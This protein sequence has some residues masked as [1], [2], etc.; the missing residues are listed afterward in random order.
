MRNGLL[1]PALCDNRRIMVHPELDAYQSTRRRTLELVAD[2]SQEQ[3]DYQPRRDKWSLGEVMD[4]LVRADR[5]FHEEIA[6][7]V[8]L[9]RAGKPTWLFR[10]FGHYGVRIPFVPRAFQPLV[11]MPFNFAGM[12]LPT[13][14][15][16]K[17]TRP[18]WVP[19]RAP[20][21]IRPRQGRPV[22]ELRAELAGMLRFV[23]NTYAGNPGIRFEELRY[24]N[25]LLG[26]THVPGMLAFSAGHEERHQEQIR[27]LLAVLPGAD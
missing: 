22:D 15:R 6:E 17:M 24:Y 2:L 20:S 18:R 12:F 1:A 19:T 7:L 10:G 13:A 23:E 3:T 8:A 16:S 27:D 21:V 9:S 4:H 11:E 14:V 26:L 25:P 5:M